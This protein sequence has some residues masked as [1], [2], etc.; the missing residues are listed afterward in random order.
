[1]KKFI[2]PLLLFVVLIHA[3]ATVYTVNIHLEP[4]ISKK[5]YAS[6]QAA[7]D[8]A[9]ANDTIY[10]ERYNTDDDYSTITISKPLYIIGPGYFPGE[11]PSVQANQNIVVLYDMELS[12]GAV[13]TKLEGLQVYYD[14]GLYA[15]DVTISHCNL[16]VDVEE[17]VDNLTITKTYLDE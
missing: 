2:I 13:G 9:S 12:S 1:M 4:D 14:I 16:G 7:H 11:N 17:D 5:I 3:N 6:L 10:V 15:N 8:A